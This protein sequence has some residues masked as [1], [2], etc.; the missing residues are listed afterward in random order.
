MPRA[1]VAGQADDH[2][3]HFT[4]RHYRR[5]A[6]SSPKVAKHAPHTSVVPV[7][8]IPAC[9]SRYA[10][11]GVAGEAI[12]T[13]PVPCRRLERERPVAGGQRIPPQGRLINPRG[14]RVN[15][16]RDC[17]A[18]ECRE[19]TQSSDSVHRALVGLTCASAADT[20]IE[21][22]G[23]ARAIRSVAVGSKL[24]YAGPFERTTRHVTLSE[25]T[26]IMPGTKSI[27]ESEA[28][29]SAQSQR[30][31]IVMQAMEINTSECPRRCL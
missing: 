31:T 11:K 14:P 1:P 24:R 10:A 9:R 7:V 22:A 17:N 19:D 30:R 21:C 4:R 12:A 26:M 20:P 18:P 25:E 5:I 8:E 29:C 28:T 6:A 15:A 16:R 13:D 2:D 3:L 27:S 23:A